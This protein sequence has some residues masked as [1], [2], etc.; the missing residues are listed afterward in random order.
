MIRNYAKF[1]LRYA[2]WHEIPLWSLLYI[3]F[4]IPGQIVSHLYRKI[5]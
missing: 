1:A 5:F 3:W 4:W 2:R